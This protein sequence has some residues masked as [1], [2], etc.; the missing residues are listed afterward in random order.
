[1][2]SFPPLAAAI[3]VLHTVVTALAAVL[4]PLLGPASAAGAIVLLTIGVRIALLPLAWRQALA[5]RNRLR[6]APRV[7]DLQR[8]HRRNPD[9]LRRE[10]AALHAREGVS[11]VAGILPTLGQAPVFL[12]LYGL[13]LTPEVGGQANLLMTHT[14]AGTPLDSRLL[15]AAGSEIVVFAVLLGLLALVALV[16]RRLMPA[17]DAPGAALVRVLPFGTVLVAAFVP[18]AA[19]LYLLTSTSW[20]VTERSTLRRL[21]A[22]RERS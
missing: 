21:A 8:R 13:F 19:G 1:M 20:T 9:R 17:A 15:D 12:A 16:A 6:I 3:G 5:E 18:I 2:Y 14:L 22:R 10:L 11:P 4:A 7:R